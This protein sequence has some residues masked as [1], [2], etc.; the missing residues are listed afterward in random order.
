VLPEGVLS[1]IRSAILPLPRPGADG[2]PPFPL[3]AES[4]GEPRAAFRAVERAESSPPAIHE[5]GFCAGGP[6]GALPRRLACRERRERG[7][8]REPA[9]GQLRSRTVIVSFPQLDI[10]SASPDWLIEVRAVANPLSYATPHP[11]PRAYPPGDTTKLLCAEGVNM[12]GGWGGGSGGGGGGGV[13]EGG[14]GFV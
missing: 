1:P 14:V 7:S 12:G 9:V 10:R 4:S 8:T 2:Q 11:D 5:S 6:T 13:A 3:G